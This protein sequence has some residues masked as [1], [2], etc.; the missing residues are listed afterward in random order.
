METTT[1]TTTRTTT[2]IMN[3]PKSRRWKLNQ[4]SQ[5]SH[6]FYLAHQ[7][8]LSFASIGHFVIRS[9]QLK[10]CTGFGRVWISN[11]ELNAHKPHM[12]AIYWPVCVC[13]EVYVCFWLLTRQISKKIQ[14]EQN[15]CNFTCWRLVWI[16]I[17]IKC[18][19]QRS[20][21]EMEF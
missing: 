16:L 2:T 17:S 13:V 15:W 8:S 14:H 19:Q 12:S 5:K 18:E 10:C 7:R 1:T 21:R 11:D 3:Q 4:S 20:K 6:A 9:N